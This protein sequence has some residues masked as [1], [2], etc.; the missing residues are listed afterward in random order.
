MKTFKNILEAGIA[1]TYDD[2]PT[3][4]F[5]KEVACSSCGKMVKVEVAKGKWRKTAAEKSGGALYSGKNIVCKECIKKS[6]RT[7]GDTK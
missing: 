6:I 5:V 7:P 3:A 4:V 1:G 2:K